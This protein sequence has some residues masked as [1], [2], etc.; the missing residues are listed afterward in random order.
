VCRHLPLSDV[1]PEAQ[2]AAEAAEAAAEQGAFWQ[3]HDLLFDHQDALRP[4]DLVRYA[5]RLGLDVDRFR[6][7]LRGHTGAA[8]APGCLRTRTAARG[9]ERNR[10]PRRCR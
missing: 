2:T 5:G 9:T 1:H 3:M 8:R 6:E 7:A 4:R 10:P